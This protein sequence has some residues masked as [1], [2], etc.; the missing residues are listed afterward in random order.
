MGIQG[1]SQRDYISK[2]RGS[3]APPWERRVLQPYPNG[4]SQ[5]AGQCGTP[6]GYNLCF[7][8]TQGALRDPGL[9]GTAL[10]FRNGIQ[11]DAIRKSAP[12]CAICGSDSM[13]NKSG[14]LARARSFPPVAP[15]A[16]LRTC[17]AAPSSHS[18]TQ[19]GDWGGS[20]GS[21]PCT[22]GGTCRGRQNGSPRR[23][24]ASCPRDGR[25]TCR[26]KIP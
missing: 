6:L 26:W 3:I 20:P 12:I 14:K 1:L 25:G 10:G 8:I 11:G 21:C 7:G 22:P 5:S 2:P 4:V 23:R 9:C 19:T 16:W 13:K 15:R 24:W 17:P 18:L